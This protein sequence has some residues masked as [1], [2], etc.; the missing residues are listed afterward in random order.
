MTNL[1][2]GH[3]IT[4]LSTW[5]LSSTLWNLDLL[6]ESMFNDNDV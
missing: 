5:S 2:V 6:F 3:N 1:F 4:G